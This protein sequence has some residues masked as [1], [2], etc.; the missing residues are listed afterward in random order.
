M[1]FH[2]TGKGNRNIVSTRYLSGGNKAMTNLRF[3]VRF[4]ERVRKK[5]SLKRTA[6]L[7]VYPLQ[8]YCNYL[9]AV[10]T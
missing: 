1:A 5:I 7:A 4:K 6:V 8:I 3:K 2:A 9:T 10:I